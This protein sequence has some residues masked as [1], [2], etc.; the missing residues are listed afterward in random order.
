M[1]TWGGRLDDG[2]TSS[3]FS[4]VYMACVCVF[5]CIYSYPV[6]V[7]VHHLDVGLV[8]RIIARVYS[9][10]VCVCSCA[11]ICMCVCVCVHVSHLDFRLAN[12]KFSLVFLSCVCRCVHMHIYI[13]TVCVCA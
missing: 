11:C 4:L 10:C 7:R 5:M 8:L 3:E 12:F 13:L 2:L 1:C 9:V 6:C